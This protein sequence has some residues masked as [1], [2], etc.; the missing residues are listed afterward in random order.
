MVQRRKNDEAAG[1][2]CRVGRYWRKLKVSTDHSVRRM[3]TD[4]RSVMS[5]SES[6]GL[7]TPAWLHGNRYKADKKLF[8][9]EDTVFGNVR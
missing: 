3:M 2:K 8:S 5:L 4:H 6:Q 7:I 1:Y 9:P